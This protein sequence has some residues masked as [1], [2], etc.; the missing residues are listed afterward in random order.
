M[1]AKILI[2]VAICSTAAGMAGWLLLEGAWKCELAGGLW[3][4]DSAD[5]DVW[6][7]RAC[8]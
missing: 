5:E 6:D 8:T 4:V 3:D 7:L 2:S 1:L